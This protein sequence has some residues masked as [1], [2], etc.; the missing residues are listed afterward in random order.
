MHVTY[1]FFFY[2]SLQGTS[3]YLPSLENVHITPA[4]FGQ[5]FSKLMGRAGY[6]PPRNE[7]TE[8]CVTALDTRLAAIFMQSSCGQTNQSMQGTI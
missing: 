4:S 1:I 8:N 3:G 5:P 7:R 6:Q 2:C